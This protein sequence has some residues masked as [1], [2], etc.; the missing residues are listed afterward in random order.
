MSSAFKMSIFVSITVMLAATITCLLVVALTSPSPPRRV[1]L[2]P[3]DDDCWM[4]AARRVAARRGRRFDDHQLAHVL[5]DFKQHQGRRYDRSAAEEAARRAAPHAHVV[6]LGAGRHRGIP[7]LFQLAH[8]TLRERGQTVHVVINKW[9]EPMSR[10]CDRDRDRDDVSPFFA[11]ANKNAPVSS[12]LFP[13]FSNCKPRAS[14]SCYGD[15]VA[16]LDNN[17]ACVTRELKTP[18]SGV[19]WSAKQ[20][21]VVWRGSSTG[22]AFDV[23]PME[24][25]PRLKL[26]DW[27]RS[28][29]LRDRLHVDVALTGHPQLPSDAAKTT[30]LQR[31]YPAGRASFIDVKDQFN[32]K[33]LIVVDGNTW[34]NRTAAFLHSGSVVLLATAFQDWVFRKLVPW[35]HYVPIRLDFS[36]LDERLEWLMDND[37]VARSIGAAGRKHAEEELDMLSMQL[38]NTAITLA[39]ADL[40]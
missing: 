11:D 29:P 2:D 8:E 34:P 5:A 35:V 22:G 38:Y 33:Y 13:Y 20:N 31:L 40:F 30:R 26:I 17:G 15:I 18:S 37:A 7:A 25:Y 28:S 4:T 32:A 39:L 1:R 23:V 14:S 10:A 3:S 24:N 36:D 12:S 9:D 6:T 16:C 27:A 19:P 21:R